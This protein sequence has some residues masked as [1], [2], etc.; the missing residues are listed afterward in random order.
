MVTYR[1]NGDLAELTAEAAAR[2][3]TEVG[4]EIEVEAYLGALGE[5]VAYVWSR[6]QDGQTEFCVSDAPV[7][8]DSPDYE[9]FTDAGRALF[10]ACRRVVE[11]G[12]RRVEYERAHP[13]REEQTDANDE[14]LPEP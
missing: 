14:A 7:D 6:Q 5:H 8:V 10:E 12:Q 11:Q 2:W 1:I 13:E 3:L 9:T 4:A